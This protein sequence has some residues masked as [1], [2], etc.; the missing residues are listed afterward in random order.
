MPSDELSSRSPSAKR[1]RDKHSRHHSDRDSKSSRQ[2]DSS[3]DRH[4][5]SHR[6][7][8]RSRSPRRRRSRSRDRK[9]RRSPSRPHHRNNIHDNTYDYDAERTRARDAKEQRRRGDDADGRDNSGRSAG[10]LPS[11]ESSWAVTRGEAPPVDKEK[12]NYG[13]TGVLAA[14]S[15]SVKKADGTVIRLKYV[16]PQDGCRPG[17]RQEWRLFVFRGKDAKD[18]IP[19]GER[20][21]WLFGREKTVVDYPVD[22]GSVSGQH[23]VLQFRKKESRNEFGDRE[24]RVKLYVIDLESGNGTR[25]NGE[26][27][28]ASRYVELRANDVLKLGK[29][30]TEYVVVLG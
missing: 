16:E 11:Q 1:S 24:E 15:N 8:S 17:K 18:T 22:H 6:H 12:P 23:A 13:T 7:R 4:S 19:L 21:M 30:S 10:P 26:K 25:L 5:R 27:I 14:E 29:S 9:H 28:P 2:C 20:S 3:K